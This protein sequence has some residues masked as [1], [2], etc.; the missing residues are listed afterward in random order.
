MFPPI[1]DSVLQSNPDFAIAYNKL[2]KAILN[3]DGTTKNDPAAKE[4]KR[5]R[6]VR[7]PPPILVFVSMPLYTMSLHHICLKTPALTNLCFSLKE[8]DKHRLKA[9]KQ[10]ILTRAIA[11]VAPSDQ[12]PRAIAAD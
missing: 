6:E 2:T 3:Q 12:P 9:A 4:R 1:D 7:F 8:L 5:V 10:H 11:T